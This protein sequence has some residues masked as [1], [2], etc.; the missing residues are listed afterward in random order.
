MYGP[1]CASD[2]FLMDI[3]QEVSEPGRKAAAGLRRETR[4]WTVWQVKIADT[5]NET[6]DADGP[7]NFNGVFLCLPFLQ[8][9]INPVSGNQPTRPRVSGK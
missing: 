3:M 6:F 9:T 4:L 1:G 8:R 2:Q 5:R 7:T